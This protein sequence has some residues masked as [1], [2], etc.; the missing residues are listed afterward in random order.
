MFHKWYFTPERVAKIYPNTSSKCW[1]GCD[2]IGSLSHRECPPIKK[3]WE[4]VRKLISSLC[5]ISI[6]MSPL[7]LLLGLSIPTWPRHL[8]TLVTHILIAAR[9]AI[10]KKWKLIH[11]S[12]LKD[13]IRLLNLHYLMECSFAKANISTKRFTKI[14][15]LWINDCRSAPLC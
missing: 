15:K 13:I 14:W 7:N 3:F 12:L 8:Q 11:P 10:A 5:G 9:L 2:N 1:R 4:K 6:P